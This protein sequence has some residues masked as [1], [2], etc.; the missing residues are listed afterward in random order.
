MRQYESVNGSTLTAAS[1]MPTMTLG[2][3]EAKAKDKL[4]GAMEGG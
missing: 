4:E 1:V 2:I 3:V